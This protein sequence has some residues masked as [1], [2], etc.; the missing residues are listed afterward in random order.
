MY[1]KRVLP[2]RRPISWIEWVRDHGVL[3]IRGF[4]I[5]CRGF[6]I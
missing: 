6:L 2:D 5:Q 1:A 3:K 4:G